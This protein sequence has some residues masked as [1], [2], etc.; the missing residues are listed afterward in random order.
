[1]A[2]NVVEVE[3]TLFGLADGEARGP[4]RIGLLHRE[5]FAA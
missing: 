5:G 1:L 4:R 2:W 3:D